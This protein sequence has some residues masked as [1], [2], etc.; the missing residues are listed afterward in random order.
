MK[1]VCLIKFVPDVEEFKYDFQR[2]VLIRENLKQILNP[3]DACALA[4]ALM[5]KRSNPETII[6]IVTMAPCSVMAQLEDLLRRNIDQA[7]LVSDNLFSG[8][9][10][11]ATT[12]VLARY[13]MQT[14]YDVILTGTHSLDGDTSQVP[15]QLAE[16]CGLSHVSNIISIDASSF[17]S[18]KPRVDVDHDTSIMTF[19]VDLPAII[20]VHKDSAYKLPFVAYQD[21]NKDVSS[22]IRVITHLELGILPHECGLEG[23]KTKVARAFV[24]AVS[25][26][27]RVILNNDKDGIE[28][29]YW[30]LEEHGFLT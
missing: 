20:S 4:Y 15:S 3:D 14:S 30:Y 29:V 13:L 8:S 2:H 9:D 1:I 28:T 24:Q 16:V 10:T 26:K 17:L 23:S 27:D 11:F 19:A 7:T 22:R 25:K 18:G 12:S 5:I 21:L 6:E